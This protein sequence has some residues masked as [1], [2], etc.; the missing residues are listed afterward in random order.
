MDLVKGSVRAF[1][2]EDGAK[3]RGD[4]DGSPGFDPGGTATLAAFG[5]AIGFDQRRGVVGEDELGGGA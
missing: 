3:R 5:D 2:H 4:M 1:D